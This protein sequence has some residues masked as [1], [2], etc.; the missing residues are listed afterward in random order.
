MKKSHIAKITPAVAPPTNHEVQRPVIT[1]DAVP[2]DPQ[3]IT[4]LDS[5]FII[6]TAREEKEWNALVLSLVTQIVAETRQHTPTS[7]GVDAPACCCTHPQ[8]NT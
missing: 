2:S 5:F 6:F 3:S 7:K 4:F 1:A 8:S